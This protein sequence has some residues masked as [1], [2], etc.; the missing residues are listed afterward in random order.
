[1]NILA[2]GAFPVKSVLHVAEGAVAPLP[3][4]KTR[5]DDVAAHEADKR[6]LFIANAPTSALTLVSPR[7]QKALPVFGLGMS[8]FQA[9]GEDVGPNDWTQEAK[10]GAARSRVPRI[11]VPLAGGFAAF[12]EE[13]KL[14]AATGCNAI[15]F[16]IEW[17][18]LFPGQAD[19]HDGGS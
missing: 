14:V 2:S 9:Y 19:E 17:G 4:L 8:T 1:M 12:E 11:G 3:E 16:S 15:R 5:R 7:G 6:K 18:H 10:K 13:I